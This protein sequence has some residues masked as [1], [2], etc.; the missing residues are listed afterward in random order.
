MV[1]GA[2]GAGT[3]GLGQKLGPIPSVRSWDSRGQTRFFPEFSLTT[4]L[5]RKNLL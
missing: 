4:P 3:G 5:S 2:F 1:F